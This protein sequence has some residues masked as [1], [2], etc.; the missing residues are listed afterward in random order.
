MNELWSKQKELDFFNEARQFAGPEQLF[1]LGDDSRYYA[2]WPKSYHGNK[3]TLQSRNAL[4]GNYTEK[5]DH[6][7]HA[8]IIQGF[9]SVNS[10]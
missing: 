9:W 1:Y 3:S 7:L 8:G 10:N 5:I 2:Y 6:L 4:I